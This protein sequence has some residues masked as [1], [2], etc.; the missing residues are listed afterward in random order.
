[1][2][3]P[4]KWLVSRRA[5]NGLTLCSYIPRTSVWVHGH[6]LAL[7]AK[8]KQEIEYKYMHPHMIQCVRCT[9]VSV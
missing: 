2:L 7:Q 6:T 1:M 4:D 8:K 3:V 5:L 9:M